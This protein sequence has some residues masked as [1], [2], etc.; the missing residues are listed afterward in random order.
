MSPE[1]CCWRSHITLIWHPKKSCKNSMTSDWCSKI[2]WGGENVGPFSPRAPKPEILSIRVQ[3][4]MLLKLVQVLQWTLTHNPFAIGG[5]PSRF[6]GGNHTCPL[7]LQH[8]FQL[9]KLHKTDITNTIEM[10]FSV[11]NTSPNFT[12][13]LSSFCLG[14]LLCKMTRNMKELQGRTW[15]V[16]LVPWVL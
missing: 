4:E 12:S 6:L 3:H 11:L 15:Y 7:P 10:K 8:L 2:P 5:F 9:S 13:R 1:K 14:C 16:L